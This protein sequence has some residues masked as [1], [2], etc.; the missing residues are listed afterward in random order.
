MKRCVVMTGV[1]EEE[2]LNRE[3]RKGPGR[4]GEHE[5]MGGRVVFISIRGS[6]FHACNE[7]ICSHDWGGGGGG[8]GGDTCTE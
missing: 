4:E 6:V 7:E 8:G 3:R 1:A 2:A 5:V